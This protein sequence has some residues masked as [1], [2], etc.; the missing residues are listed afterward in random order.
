MPPACATRGISRSP[1][2]ARNETT[3]GSSSTESAAAPLPCRE[4]ISH[5]TPEVAADHGRPRTR[6]WTGI[7]IWAV[8]DSSIARQTSSETWSAPRDASAW[9]LVSSLDE[10][11]RTFD[12]FRTGLRQL[13]YEEGRNIIIDFRWAEGRYDRL[14]ELAAELVKLNVDVIVTYSA[15]GA[16]A[17]KQ[18]TSTIPIVAA[19]VGDPVDFGLVVSLHRP[20]GN[21]TG[22][23]R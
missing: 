12:A 15:P 6:T 23:T 4:S 5:C 20:G 14:A 16:R 7:S 10:G 21:L 2:A 3:L 19:S 9:T 13:G 8:F 18:A 17:A 22:L 11:R 1:A